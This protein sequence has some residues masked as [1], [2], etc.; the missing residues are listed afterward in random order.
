MSNDIN[1]INNN[2]TNNNSI[3]SNSINSD[4]SCHCIYNSIKTQL[5]NNENCNVC[6]N[7]SFASCDK[8]LYWSSI[9]Y[10]LPRQEIKNQSK[11][12]WFNCNKCTHLFDRSLSDILRN[13]WCKYCAKIELCNNDDCEICFKK[14]FQS[15]EKSKFWSNKNKLSPRQV[16]KCSN[17]K[18]FF[19]CICGH[20][21]FKT[22]GQIQSGSWCVYCAGQRLCKNIECKI[23]FERSFATHQK[24]IYWSDKNILLPY[25]IFKQTNDKYYFDCVCGHTFESIISN[26]VCLNRWCPY[27]SHQKLCNTYCKICFDKS[28]AS[29]EK[30]IHWSDKNKLKPINVFK[31]SSIKFWFNCENGHEFNI[32]LYAIQNGNWCSKCN[33]K[34]EKKLY[35]EIIK[36]YPNVCHQYKKSW[37][38]NNKTNFLFPFDF[39][40]ID[41]KIII[42]LDGEQ[43]FKQI[44]NWKKPELQ[45]TNDIYKMKCANENNFSII[46]LLQTD[47][48]N[49]KYDWKSE[50]FL[51]IE[52][53]K[54]NNNKIINIFM[55]KN[56]EYDKI[57]QLI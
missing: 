47:V 53:I 22:L 12:F 2:S 36:K 51:N 32:C 21:L 7:K 14:S 16:F 54:K 4:S 3:N 20:E 45:L 13:K 18:F 55:C 23:C 19:D 44:S 49:D 24:S 8:S 46:R 37:C 15:N 39:S 17:K 6:F 48:Y 26:I 52:K 30:S 57:Q 27:C 29:H 1:S 28:F 38:K 42:E 33:N 35:D 50:L 34:T 11:K 40:L 31:S 10:T 9:N 43:H 25:Q 5:C 41:E 56:N